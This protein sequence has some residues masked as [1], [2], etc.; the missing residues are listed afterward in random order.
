MKLSELD[1]LAKKEKNT[2]IIKF[3]EKMSKESGENKA[4]FDEAIK[5]MMQG[6][7]FKTKGN[8]LLSFVKGLN[9]MPAFITTFAISPIILGWFIP[10]LTYANTRRIHAKKDREAKN[11]VN[12]AA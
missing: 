8:K 5:K 6:S 11:K 10:R 7:E 1:N 12:T 3:F 9:S 4:K 2:K